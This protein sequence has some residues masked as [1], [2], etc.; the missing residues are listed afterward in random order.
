METLL[1]S[2]QTQKIRQYNLSLKLMI[3]V[4]EN[5]NY[6]NQTPTITE[7]LRAFQ[8]ATKIFAM[9]A[10]SPRLPDIQEAR[11]EMGGL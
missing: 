9:T 5:T 8:I 10:L 1:L 11:K 7:R 4:L 6:K 3:E 2:G